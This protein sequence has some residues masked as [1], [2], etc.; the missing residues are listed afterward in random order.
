MSPPI[1]R[2]QSD[3]TQVKAYVEGLDRAQLPPVSS[4]NHYSQQVQYI[5]VMDMYMLMYSSDMEITYIIIIAHA[6]N[7]YCDLLL[8]RYSNIP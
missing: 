8:L 6:L 4:N 7:E 3:L 2:T 5:T 1:N